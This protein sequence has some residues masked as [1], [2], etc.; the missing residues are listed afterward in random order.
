MARFEDTPGLFGGEGGG[1]TRGN[2][3]C[4]WCGKRYDEREDAIGNHIG[5]EYITVTD[6]GEKQIC[7]CCFETVENAVLARMTDIIPW[8]IRILE[9]KQKNLRHRREQIAELKKALAHVA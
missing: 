5:D 2:T 1:E 4:D 8:Y 6:F 9:S 3:T 7:D